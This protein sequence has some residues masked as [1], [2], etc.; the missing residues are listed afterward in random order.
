MELKLKAEVKGDIVFLPHPTTIT[1]RLQD[2]AFG[3]RFKALNSKGV[4]TH[5]DLRHFSLI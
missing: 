5:V 4:S 3:L 1:A 2:L